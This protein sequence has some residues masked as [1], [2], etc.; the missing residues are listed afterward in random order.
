MIADATV[1]IAQPMAGSDVMG[2]AVTVRLT[3]TGVPIVPAGDLTPLTGHHY[4]YLDADLTA[5]GQPAPSVPGSIVHM[6]DASSELT[7][8]DVGPRGASTHRRGSQRSPCAA[9]ALGHRHGHLHRVLGPI[10]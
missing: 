4:L 8:E 10:R 5:A 2:S 7:F 3:V 1:R 9:P 6:G